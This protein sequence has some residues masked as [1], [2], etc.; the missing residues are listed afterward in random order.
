[1]VEEMIKGFGEL[2]RLFEALLDGEL[3]VVVRVGGGGSDGGENRTAEL[4][5]EGGLA[6]GGGRGGGGR[7]W[8]LGFGRE[9]EDKERK[10]KEE[11]EQRQ[12]LRWCRHG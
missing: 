7:R 10:S 9:A 12:G 8:R 11:Q 3:A 1:M 2:A 6:G 5:V 4:G